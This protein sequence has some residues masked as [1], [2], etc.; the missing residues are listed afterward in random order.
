MINHNTRRGGICVEEAGQ[1]IKNE[2][3]RN[4]VIHKLVKE[5]PSLQDYSSRKD[6]EKACW[7]NISKSKDFLRL[8]MS[9]DGKHELVMRAGALKGIFL[10]KSYRDI[11]KEFFVSLQTIRGV[12]KAMEENEYKSYSEI[13]KE[14]RKK[15]RDVPY[16]FTKKEKHYGRMI[17][18]KYG[19]KYISF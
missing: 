19:K 1:K 15:D 16:V 11:S 17:R 10:G 14:N 5:I 8:F 9:T 13:R 3:M 18:T 6:W 12:K 4:N 7:E 2:R